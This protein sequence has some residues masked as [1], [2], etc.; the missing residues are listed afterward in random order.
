MSTVRMGV[1]MDVRFGDFATNGSLTG[2]VGMGTRN[3]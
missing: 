2:H 3:Q 1:V